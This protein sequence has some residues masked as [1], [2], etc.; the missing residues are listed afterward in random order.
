MTEP[1]PK[2]NGRLTLGLLLIG[3]GRSAGFVQFGAT[4]DAFLASLA[5]WLGL[6]IVLSGTIAW[7][8]KPIV[9]LAFFL[10]TICNLLAPA[11][12]ADAFCR[13]W[14]RRENWALYA[15]VLNCS[16][17][18][19]VA[20]FLLLLP[21]ASLTVPL[22]ASLQTA[23]WLLMASWASYVIWFHWFAARHALNISR[24][25]AVVVMLT[26]I[27]G[28]GILL[29]IPSLLVGKSTLDRLS[30]SIDKLARPAE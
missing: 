13:L 18:L 20:A 30:N 8:G 5:P 15:N 27:F 12:I 14:Q 3:T 16:Q 11:V 4:R 6:V 22:G 28:T 10:V 1:P 25:R 9:A 23:T 29:Q 7:A 26:V 17:W 24:G 2:P 19:M 21:L